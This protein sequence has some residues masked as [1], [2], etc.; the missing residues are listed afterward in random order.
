[1]FLFQLYSALKGGQIAQNR[2]VRYLDEIQTSQSIPVG[3]S[4]GGV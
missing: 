3:R 1:M 2:L 4:G